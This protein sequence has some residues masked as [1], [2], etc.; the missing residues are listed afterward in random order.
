MRRIK[1]LSKGEELDMAGTLVKQPLPTQKIE[2]LSPFLLLH[3]L[4]PTEAVPGMTPLDIAPHPHRGFEPVTFVYSGSI[5]HKDSLG[6]EGILSAGDVQWMTAGRGVIHS[7]RASNDLLYKGGVLEAIQLWVNLPKAFKMIPPKYQHIKSD[8]IPQVKKE[9]VCV[10]VV[11]GQFDHQKGPI[12]THTPLMA[13]QLDM[14]KEASLTIETPKDF[15]TMA[16]V[17][18]G[19]VRNIGDQ[20]IEN[21][22]LA[23]FEDTNE[24]LELQALSESRIL[25]LSAQAIDEPVAQ[26][27]PYVMNTQTEVLQ[28]MRDYQMGKMG[29]YID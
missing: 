26:W 3:H 27:G 6:H 29:V 16:Y 23:I 8:Q 18:S 20:P 15:H 4:G 2:R 1:Y 17:L 21:E 12:Q 11:A 28:A 24:P 25:F 14:K 10:K 9:G 5:R 13:L 7:E 19:K 22:F